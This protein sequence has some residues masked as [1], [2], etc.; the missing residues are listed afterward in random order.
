MTTWRLCVVLLLTL[1]AC[2]SGDE[3]AGVDTTAAAS[4]E[5]AFLELMRTDVPPAQWEGPNPWAGLPIVSDPGFRENALTL[6][7]GMCGQ[8]DEIPALDLPGYAE[9]HGID[10]AAYLQLAAVG[11]LCPELSDQISGEPF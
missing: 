4:P 6:G 5:S 7:R 1:G 10:R 3:E 2:S 8:I 9:I 11:T